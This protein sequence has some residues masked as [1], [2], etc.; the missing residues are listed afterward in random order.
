MEG[1]H[2]DELGDG[3]FGRDKTFAKVTERF[4]WVG[5]IKEFCRTCDKCQKANRY[6]KDNNVFF[7][8]V[9]VH[10]YT[11]KYTLHVHEHVVH[12]YK[13]TCMHTVNVCTYSMIVHIIRTCMQQMYVL[14]IL[15]SCSYS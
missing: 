11:H 5:I 6:V 13:C 8:N 9:H 15:H 4:Y 12:E 7:S 14:Y 3:H 1:C 10:T 2:C